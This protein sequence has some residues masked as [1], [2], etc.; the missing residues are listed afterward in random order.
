MSLSSRIYVYYDAKE[1]LELQYKGSKLYFSPLSSFCKINN[2]VYHLTYPTIQIN[3]EIYIST[4]SFFKILNKT[5]IPIQIQ[6][7]KDEEIIL[8]TDSYNINSFR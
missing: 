8:I 2:K 6:K 3:N 5:N 4:N 7:T 1:K